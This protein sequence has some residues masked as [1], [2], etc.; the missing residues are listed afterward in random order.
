[1]DDPIFAEYLAALRAKPKI[2]SLRR[3]RLSYAKLLIK[4][5]AAYNRAY[6]RYRKVVKADMA[7]AD[8]CARYRRSARG[9][10]ER[11]QKDLNTL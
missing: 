9:K 11:I 10:A 1:M 2:D 6:A 8:T 3:M 4:D 7:Y 5:K